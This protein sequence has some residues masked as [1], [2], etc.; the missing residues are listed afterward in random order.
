MRKISV[1]NIFSYF[2][3]ERIGLYADYNFTQNIFSLKKASK[4][5]KI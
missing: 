4:T 3:L 1:K 5:R 2:I